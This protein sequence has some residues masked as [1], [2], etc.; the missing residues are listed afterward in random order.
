[1]GP[2]DT[3]KPDVVPEALEVPDGARQFGSQLGF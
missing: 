1:M 3:M 2:T